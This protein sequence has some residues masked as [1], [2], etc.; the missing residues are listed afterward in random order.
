MAKK[1]LEVGAQASGLIKGPNK[2]KI[3]L[4]FFAAKALR[5]GITSLKAG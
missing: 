4:T 3:V 2:L 5:T 1:R